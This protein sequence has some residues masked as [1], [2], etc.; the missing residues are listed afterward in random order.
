MRYLY[1]GVIVPA[2]IVIP[3]CI[4]AY[5]YKILLPAYRIILYYLLFAGC[6]NLAADVLAENHIRNLPLLHVYTA[7]EAMLLLWFYRMIFKGTKPA[8]AIPLIMMT[9]FI[10]CVVNAL[11]FKAFIALIPIRGRWRQLLL[12]ASA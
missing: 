12:R 2:S 5:R 8:P 9:F 4:A 1:E 7:I 11:F 6:I 10:F 3:V